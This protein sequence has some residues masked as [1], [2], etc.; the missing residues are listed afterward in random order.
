MSK[1][2]SI[3]SVNDFKCLIVDAGLSLVTESTTIPINSYSYNDN[4]KA[5]RINDGSDTIKGAI[6]VALGNLSIGDTV[7]VKM[8]VMNISGTKAKIVIDAPLGT[9]IASI[10]SE[11][12]GEFE[13]I[14]GKFVVI[15][16]NKTTLVLGLST[17]DIGDFYMRNVE[18]VINGGVEGIYES[19]SN[20]SGDFIKFNDGTMICNLKVTLDGT[21]IT[22]VVGSIFRSGSKTFSFPAPFI[23]PPTVTSP[24]FLGNTLLWGSGSDSTNTLYYFYIMSPVSVTPASLTGKATAIGRWM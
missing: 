23:E 6:H 12:T 24:I 16:N 5:F 17:A 3:K 19:G 1:N 15:S 4:Y 2:I 11:K 18:I 14:G 21:P 7:E 13:S 10:Q 8:E 9:P 20:A 22:V